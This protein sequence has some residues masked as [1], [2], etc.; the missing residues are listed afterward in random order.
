MAL[1]K[2]TF[3]L[4][5]ASEWNYFIPFLAK[6]ARNETCAFISNIDIL[7]IPFSVGPYRYY[8]YHKLVW[9]AHVVLESGYWQFNKCSDLC[10]T[11]GI[12]GIYLQHHS[13]IHRRVLKL[14]RMNHKH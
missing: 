10:G 3:E 12:Y 2:L 4:A 6:G 11:P 13:M 14:Q 8:K 7:T 5:R 1:K 9:F